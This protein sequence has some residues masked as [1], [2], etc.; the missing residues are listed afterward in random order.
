MNYLRKAAQELN[1]TFRNENSLDLA[2][3]TAS[4]VF[5]WLKANGF[6]Q[7][8]ARIGRWVNGNTQLIF[9]A[10]AGFLYLPSL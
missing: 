10:S 8:K 4:K 5:G 6:T 2:N 9:D 3:T 7:S 1:C